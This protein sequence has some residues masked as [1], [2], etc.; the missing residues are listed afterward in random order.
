MTCLL[1]VRTQWFLEVCFEPLMI[2][3][4]FRLAISYP[5]RLY[6]VSH[7]N[8]W[9]CSEAVDVTRSERLK[10]TIGEYF[11]A[12][13]ELAHSD[14]TM[15]SFAREASSQAAPLV[16]SQVHATLHGKRR[17][18]CVFICVCISAAMYTLHILLCTPY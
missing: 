8:V 12:A 7:K 9:M 13:P 17:F 6:R 5:T 18:Q 4:A 11:E 15:L 10:A 3:E 14:I 2:C 1:S 16:S